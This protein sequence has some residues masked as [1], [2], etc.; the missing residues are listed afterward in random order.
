M[1][2]AQRSDTIGRAVLLDPTVAISRLS[3][4]RL[5]RV[6]SA[7]R[8]CTTVQS[9]LRRSPTTTIRAPAVVAACVLAAWTLA[10]TIPTQTAAEGPVGTWG[11]RTRAKPL[12]GAMWYQSGTAPVSVAC[13]TA[14][15]LLACRAEAI[16]GWCRPRSS[17]S[18][19]AVRSRPHESATWD[20]IEAA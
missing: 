14:F 17:K 6:H 4:A 10:A 13:S 15:A 3:V 19:Q 16:A 9:A 11:P 20:D 5:W 2:G 7:S 12:V 18:V 8:L 1:E